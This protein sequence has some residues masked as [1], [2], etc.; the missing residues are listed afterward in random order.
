MRCQLR[1]ER[2]VLLLPFYIVRKLSML[3]SQHWLSL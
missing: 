3:F 1:E 2:V